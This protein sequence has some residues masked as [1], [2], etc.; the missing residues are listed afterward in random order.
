MCTTFLYFIFVLVE[1]VNF[2]SIVAFTAT[3]F[4]KQYCFCSASCQVGLKFYKLKAESVSTRAIYFIFVF[5]S[6]P[7]TWNI[8]LLSS[9]SSL[10][11]ICYSWCFLTCLLLPG[12]DGNTEKKLLVKHQF[13]RRALFQDQMSSILPPTTYQIRVVTTYKTQRLL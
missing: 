3:F 7:E 11:G 4:C 1:L 10:F 5:A 8:K 13:M 9:K 6:L 2:F 12:Y